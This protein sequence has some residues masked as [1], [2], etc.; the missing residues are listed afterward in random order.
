M[1]T[2]LGIVPPVS[3]HG[4]R[5]TYASRPA[6]RGVPLA[7]IAAQLGHAATRMVDLGTPMASK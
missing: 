2:P 4:L 6:M 3:F 7:V 1:P 5:H